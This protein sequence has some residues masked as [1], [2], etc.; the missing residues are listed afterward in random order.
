MTRKRHKIQKT[1]S[2]VLFMLSFFYCTLLQA[3][4]DVLKSMNDLSHVADYQGII[5]YSNEVLRNPSTQKNLSLQLFC[6]AQAAQSYIK[7][8]W[9]EKAMEYLNHATNII[10][11]IS[12]NERESK[13]YTE[14]FYTV[15]TGYN[16]YLS[17]PP[18]PY[19]RCQAASKGRWR[20]NQKSLPAT[21]RHH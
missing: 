18:A 10:P 7:T 15:L 9:S 1:L 16:F 4:E 13:L 8:D 11:D 6:L 3:Q 14:S 5:D 20:I 21:K 19:Q 2:R 12:T 17:S